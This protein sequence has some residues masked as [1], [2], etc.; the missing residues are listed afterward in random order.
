MTTVVETRTPGDRLGASTLVGREL[1]LAGLQ[2]V[3]AALRAGHSTALVMLGEAGVG[4]TALLEHLREQMTE[5]CV[6]HVNAARVETGL[7]Y[8]TLNQVCQPLTE[9][10]D[11]L[12]SP[13]RAALH[14][15]LGMT[16]ATATDRLLLGGAVLSLMAE[17]SAERPVVCLI[18]DAQW[19]D[20]ASAAV[21]AFAARRLG[22]G[23]AGRHA[24]QL[25]QHL[26]QRTLAPLHHL[27]TAG[28]PRRHAA[29]HYG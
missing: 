15:A 19:V 12:P 7:P 21:L 4:K 25:R 5:C 18:D 16:E 6:V 2:S 26:H 24:T 9:C 29:P 13:H 23:G 11:A 17:A 27:L 14:A 22:G 8:S 1:E 20:D 10:V 3:R 28:T